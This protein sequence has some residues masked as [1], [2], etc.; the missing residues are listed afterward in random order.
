[1][2]SFGSSNNRGNYLDGL[3]YYFAPNDY[4]GSENSIIFADRQGLILNQKTNIKIVTNLAVDST[5]KFVNI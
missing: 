3:G 1:M 4:F 5:L 2:P